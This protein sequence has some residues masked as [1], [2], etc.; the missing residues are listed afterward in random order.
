MRK[1]TLG[2][3]AIAGAALLSVGAVYAQGGGPPPPPGKPDASLVTAGTYTTD[4]G[5]SQVLFT[6][7]HFGFTRNMG[8]LSGADGTLTFDP[9]APNDAKLSVD[10]PINTIHTTIAALDEEFQTKA[11]F[12][13]AT[14]P[15][16]HFEST[17]VT[18]NGNNATIEGNLTIKGNTKPATIHASFAAA[19]KNPFSQKETVSF[20]GTASIKRSEFG[21]GNAVPLVA[22]QVDLTITVQ[23]EK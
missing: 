13:A 19:G 20:N 11:W 18:A 8:L 21:L 9:K 16:A 22:D 17:K 1:L 12:D 3:A 6:Y 2:A 15:T 5:H 7:E 14:Y 4:K 10:M 23:F